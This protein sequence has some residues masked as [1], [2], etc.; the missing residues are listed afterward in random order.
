MFINRKLKL[1]LLT[2]VPFVAGS[3]ILSAQSSTTTITNAPGLHSTDT[4][5]TGPSGKTATYQNNASWGNGSYTDNRSVTGFNGK[6][7]SSTTTATHSSGTYSRD[8]SV[9][10]FNGRTSS[11]QKNASWGNGAYNATKVYTG[12][13]G[14]TGTENINRSNGQLTK[15]FTG[16]DGHSRTSSRPIRRRRW[17]R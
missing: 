8:T 15:T 5:I 12:P 10:G 11:Y 1:C 4:T 14:R 7:A 6:T 16:Q 3:L 13:N 2:S 17:R 9:T